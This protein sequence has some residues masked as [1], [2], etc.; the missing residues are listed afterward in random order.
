[1]TASDKCPLCRRPYYGPSSPVTLQGRPVHAACAS[2]SLA[3]FSKALEDCANTSRFIADDVASGNA[4]LEAVFDACRK[5]L[6]MGETERV[7]RPS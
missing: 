5:A 1:M 3:E 4:R 6:H 7:R 2:R